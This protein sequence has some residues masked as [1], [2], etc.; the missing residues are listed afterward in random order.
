M[1]K[2]SGVRTFGGGGGASSASGTL[3]GIPLAHALA[4]VRNK[5]LSGVLD[6]RAS[7][8][9]HAWLVFSEGRVVSG[10]TTPAI[11]RFGTVVY[12]MGFIGASVLDAST[13]VSVQTKRPQMDVLLEKGAITTEQRDAILVEQLR[14]RVHHLFTLPATTTFTFRE[15]APSTTEPLVSVDLLGPLWRGLCDFPPDERAAEVLGRVGE[16]PM[17]MV[18][19]SVMELAGLSAEEH[20]LCEALARS[21]MTLWQLRRSSKLRT[22]RVDLLAYLLIISRCVEVDG[23]ERPAL[24]SGAMWAA[25]TVRSSSDK[26]DAVVGPPAPTVSTEIVHV[27]A[28]PR[29]PADLGAEAIRLRAAHLSTETPFATLG[30]AEGAS[31]E[32]A[33]AAFFR[34]GRLWHPDRTPPALED[35]RAEIER[36]F[37]HMTLAHRLLTDPD[38]RPAVVARVAR[39]TR[40]G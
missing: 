30:L 23:A 11:A 21:P 38:A 3:S 4:Y 17:R 35:V 14:R 31:A 13:I 15:G 24:P 6:L 28:P 18:S 8:T 20:A 5:R 32:A 19:E 27:S 36:I 40:E 25:A 10:M 12:E 7:A 37:A 29:G 39:N 16:H 33:R 22:G 2:G 26:I 1:S 34:L 9:R